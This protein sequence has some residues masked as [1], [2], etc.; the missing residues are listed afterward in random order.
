MQ[1][2]QSD[3]LVCTSAQSSQLIQLGIKP[4][5]CFCYQW[6]GDDPVGSASTGEYEFA[7][8]YLDQN[9][10]LPAW[11]YEELLVMVGPECIKPDLPDMR[12]WRENADMMLFSVH[13]PSKRIDYKTGAP[14]MAEWLIFLLKG[15]HITAADANE[16][17]EYYVSGKHYN[18]VLEKMKKQKKGHA[19]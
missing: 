6:F 11:T 15:K 12:E 4:V 17:M 14:A 13:L 9:N 1:K 7:G 3:K 16:R 8:E 2:I 18:T 19:D 10:P 5:G